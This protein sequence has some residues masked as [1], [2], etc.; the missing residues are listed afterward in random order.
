ME[1]VGG[2]ISG[3]QPDDIGLILST[4]R[5]V[6]DCWGGYKYYTDLELIYTDLF[7]E[8]QGAELAVDAIISI[9]KVD[10]PALRFNEQSP[11]K[12]VNKIQT[13]LIVQME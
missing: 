5:D 12:L 8:P 7:T 6:I 10:Y 11:K 3:W 1:F 2:E 9:L 13:P 4:N